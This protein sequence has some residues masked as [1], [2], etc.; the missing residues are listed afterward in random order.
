MAIQ[1]PAY[2]NALRHIIEHAGYS[3]R[4][5]HQETGIPE[6]TLYDWAAGNRVIPHRDREVL[7][8]LLGCSV[9]DLAP[10]V[11]A[12]HLVQLSQR[13]TNEQERGLD[14]DKT[15]RLLLQL[16][17]FG[18]VALFT[19]PQEMLSLEPWRRLASS[20]ARPAD[21]DASTLDHFEK[22]TALCWGSSNG[23]SLDVVKHLLPTFLPQLSA[24]AQQPTE[25]QKKSACL[26]S[27]GYQLS[28]VI[29]SHRE[30]FNA[31]LTACKRAYYFGKV[32]QDANLQAAALI[33]QGVTLLNRKRPYQ[34]LETYQQ[35][36]PLADNVSPLVRTRLY[37]GLAEVHGKLQNEQEALRSIGLAHDSFPGDP[38]RDQASLYIH[39]SYSSVFLHE[40]LA[41]LDLHQPEQ[42]AKALE[43]VDGLHPK[44]E[45]SERSRIDLLNQQ[46]LAAGQ[47]GDLDRFSEYM[48][49]AVTSACELG[50]E[51]RVSEAWDV[52]TRTRDQWKDEPRMQS[53]RSLFAR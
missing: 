25:Y 52:F 48:K 30:D 27:Q 21:M 4:E 19:S 35:A 15:R 2:P 53:L 13:Q 5:V 36:L 16:L 18:G 9:Y 43:R 11:S 38:Q 34:T 10:G 31:A 49:E 29:A 42:A 32:A 37:A 40:G 12:L 14:M 7:A 44:M 26:V 24:L 6:R 3:F 50:S 8:Q 23:G 46:A 17:G 28:Y 1:V 41:L 33:R 22:L 20:L 45:I 47:Q 39:F 51:L